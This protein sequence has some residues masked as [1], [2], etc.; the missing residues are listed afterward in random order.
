MAEFIAI[1][2]PW[3]PAVNNL[4]ANG[5]RG[6]YRTDRYERWI[7]EAAL[8]LKRQRPTPIVG[9]FKADIVLD[10]PDDRR[11]DLDGLAKAILDLLV[12]HQ[13]IVDDSLAHEIRLRWSGMPARKPGAALVMLEEAP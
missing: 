1:R 5:V 3:P 6:R 9:G 11:R 13:V 10:R 8:A 7:A 12:S 4:Y 2:L